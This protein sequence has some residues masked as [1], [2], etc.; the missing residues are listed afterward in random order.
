MENLD[1][2]V[3]QLTD[4][5]DELKKQNSKL[6]TRIHTLE[7]ENKLLKEYKQ[8]GNSLSQP[9]KPLILM[10]IALLVVFNVFTLK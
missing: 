8:P 2:T 7:I 5:N 9:R 10:G 4:E 3:K 1:V 6:L